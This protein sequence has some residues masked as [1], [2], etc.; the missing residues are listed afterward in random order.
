M[1]A[2]WHLGMPA[3]LARVLGRLPDHQLLSFSLSK[4]GASQLCNYCGLAPIIA[5]LVIMLCSAPN[6][7]RRTVLLRSIRDLH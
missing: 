2:A 5:Q 6:I 1:H 7:A 3:P 4:V